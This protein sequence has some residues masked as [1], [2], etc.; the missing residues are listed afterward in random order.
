[1]SPLSAKS[2]GASED[3]ADP[4]SD[5][6]VRG[7]A[8]RNVRQAQAPFAEQAGLP[9]PEPENPDSLASPSEEE[10]PFRSST[11]DQADELVSDDAY[12]R[13]AYRDRDDEL[14]SY[15]R[16]STPLAHD[17]DDH[18]ALSFERQ[19]A[20]SARA[21]ENV[22][23]GGTIPD[24]DDRGA[25][26]WGLTQAPSAPLRHS[27]QVSRTTTDLNSP[28]FNG[29]A[30]RPR[31]EAIREP[32]DASFA[33][34]DFETA[35]YRNADADAL[36]GGSTSSINEQD[37]FVDRPILNTPSPLPRTASE[38][39]ERVPDKNRR[40]TEDRDI[41]TGGTQPVPHPRGQI[42]TPSDVSTPSLP[43]AARGTLAPGVVSQS[44]TVRHDEAPQPT[45]LSDPHLALQFRAEH[46]VAPFQESEGVIAT[47]FP[48]LLAE[49]RAPSLREQRRESV[50]LNPPEAS[51]AAKAGEPFETQPGP[52]A[53]AV[54]SALSQESEGGTATP[55]PDLSPEVPAPSPREQKLESVSLDPPKAGNAAK[56]EKPFETQRGPSAPSVLTAPE[57]FIA[58]SFWRKS[59]RKFRKRIYQRIFA[60]AVA[61]IL[62][63]A[64][65]ALMNGTV[66]GLGGNRQ[67]SNPGNTRTTRSDSLDPAE[68]AGSSAYV[69]QSPREGDATQQNEATKPDVSESLPTHEPSL[70]ARPRVTS[71]PEN[72]S[73]PSRDTTTAASSQDPAKPD[74]RPIPALA[75]TPM[76]GTPGS[77]T[78]PAQ[79]PNTPQL[80]DPADP[81][82][83]RALASEPL[84]PP[85]SS[86]GAVESESNNRNM[87]VALSPA[88]TAD[89]T[90]EASTRSSDAPSTNRRTRRSAK[91]DASNV[92]AERLLA[93]GQIVAARLVFQTAAAE[94]DPRGARGIARTYD[95]RVINKFPASGVT[96]DREQSELWYRVANRL[97]A[98]Q[99]NRTTTRSDDKR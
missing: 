34:K 70:E 35:A 81:N 83:P 36:A 71:E 69:Q 37:R 21:S 45:L 68:P 61:A 25:G 64:T 19:D 27:S 87:T 7:Q 12:W 80:A 14:D 52:S 11:D 30:R 56:A 5:E 6:A 46:P 23:E 18:S 20:G 15:A 91:L 55:L 72:S 88:A 62:A 98:R 16:P 57:N 38:A 99:R 73:L 66:P 24:H 4:F 84:T 47:P 17:Q 1:M 65:W 28:A 67:F 8:Y 82:R 89:V 53:P 93:S 54:L 42:A 58:E 3:E 94:G 75:L 33:D 48:N 60:V 22:G 79:T 74:D 96:P 49:V 29:K 97:E 39:K 9:M 26:S 85:G 63:G 95:E 40:L 41:R 13:A 51:N 10:K 2:K 32:T 86:N 59:K 77:S 31:H 78:L 76:L 44:G 92:Q 90:P 50:S 43:P